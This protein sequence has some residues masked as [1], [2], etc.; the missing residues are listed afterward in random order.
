M[1]VVTTNSDGSPET[2]GLATFQAWP[3]ALLR[4]MVDPGVQIVS[5]RLS[6]NGTLDPQCL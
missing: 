1:D 6:V 2:T 5:E 4:S 3:W